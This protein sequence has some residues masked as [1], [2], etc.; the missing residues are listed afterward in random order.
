[1]LM[2]L[3]SHYPSVKPE[4]VM[5]SLAQGMSA[6]KIMKREDEAEKAAW[7]FAGD[8]DQFGKE[9]NNTP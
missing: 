3:Q 8:V 6:T 5:T 9:G 7:K 1:M 4:V 2:V